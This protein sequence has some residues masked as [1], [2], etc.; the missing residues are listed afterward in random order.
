MLSSAL[1]QDSSDLF[2]NAYKD[3]QTAEKLERE[4]EPQEALKKYRSALLTL[5][6]ISKSSP[7]WQPLVVDYRL[8]KTQ[9]SIE[10][11]EVSTAFIPAPDIPAPDAPEGS[12]PEPEKKEKPVPVISTQPPVVTFRPPASPKRATRETDTRFGSR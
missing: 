4:A 12:L 11:L 5:R 6:Q 10:R 9:E 1:S 8:R 7:D 3:F 2:L